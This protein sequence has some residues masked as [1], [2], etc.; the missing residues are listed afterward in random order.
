MRL[1]QT[2]LP[3]ATETWV[4]STAPGPLHPEETTASRCHQPVV[5]APRVQ[6]HIPRC[7]TGPCAFSKN[8][9]SPQG[10][11]PSSRCRDFSPG[12]AKNKL[13]N[14]PKK[15]RNQGAEA[16]GERNS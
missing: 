12:C 5:R 16:K 14:V 2:L 8:H 6:D 7:P 13:K 11:T 1:L 3:S 4:P 9:A 10:P 15:E